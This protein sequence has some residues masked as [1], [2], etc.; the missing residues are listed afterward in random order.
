LRLFIKRP[1]LSAVSVFKEQAAPTRLLMQR[2]NRKAAEK[3]D[4]DDEFF[5]CQIDE[6]SK[7][8]DVASP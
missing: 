7:L 1:H 5:G 6:L 4:Y 3:G 2:T 8:H